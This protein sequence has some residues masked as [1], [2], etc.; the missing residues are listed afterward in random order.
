LLVAPAAVRASEPPNVLWISVEDISPR[1]GAYGDSVA[2]TPNLDRLASQGTRYTHAFAVAPVCAPNRSA[3]ITG[4]YPTTI[5]THHMR[6]THEGEGLPTPYLAVPP[7]YVKG[8]PE[9][10]RAAGY[11]TTNDSKTD[12]QF[13]TPLT[14]WDESGDGAHWRNRP[15]PGQPFFAVFNITLTHESRNWAAPEAT[16]PA[17]VSVPPYYPDTPPVRASLARLYDNIA[18]MD[19]RVGELLDELEEDG[20]ADRTVVFFWSDHGD[21]LPRAKRWL[22]DSGTRFPLIVREPGQSPDVSARLVSSIDLGPTVL[23]LAGVPVPSHVQGRPFLGSQAGPHR[24]RVFAARDRFDEAYDMVRAVRGRRHLYVRNYH[25]ELPYLLFIPYRNRSPIMGELLRLH[26]EG[27][28]VGPQRLWLADRRPPEELYD[29]DADPHQ[30]SNL[31]ADPAQVDVLARLRGELDAWRRETGD[32]GD[33]PEVQLVERFW[34]RGEQPATAQPAFVVN[35]PEGRGGAARREGGSFSGP[36]T[37]SL[38][39]ATQGASIAYTTDPGE[40]PRW[41]LYSGPLRLP[42]GRTLVRARAVRYGY[43]ESPELRG[44][45]VVEQG[46]RPAT[47]PRN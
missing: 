4:M 5:G 27:A 43:A 17:S 40:D 46:Q 1:L 45:F 42:E 35:S 3:I 2:R 19:E 33:V 12:Y 7:P 29:C 32:L 6:T 38:Y 18:G 47:S 23:S 9:Y 20:L 22:Y 8:F 41:R 15:D 28:L 31:A 10:L 39:C 34:P 25:P 30:V 37:L 14:I 13:G 21:G 11:Y 44:E 26:A 16:D 36:M 24:E